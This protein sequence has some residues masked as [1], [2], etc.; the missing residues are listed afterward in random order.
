MNTKLIPVLTKMLKTSSCLTEKELNST[1]SSILNAFNN[2]QYLVHPLDNTTYLVLSHDARN[3]SNSKRFKDSPFPYLSSLE[4]F[5]NTIGDWNE[6]LEYFG[7][8]A[9]KKYGDTDQPHSILGC[10][11]H[12]SRTTSITYQ[13][14]QYLK[15]QYERLLT[16][17][18]SNRIDQY[19]K[20]SWDLMSRSWSFRLACLNSWNATWYKTLK[21]HEVKSLFSTLSKI[22]SLTEKQSPL[23]NLWIE[24][25][26]GK[27]RQLNIP[28]PGW[29]Y[30]YHML[31][32]FLSYIY[33]PRLPSKVYDGFIYNR[34]CKSWWEDLIWGT[35]LDRY[36]NIVEADLSSGFPNMNLEVVKEALLSDRLLPVPYINLILTHL[37]SPLTASKT[38]PTLQ[39]YIEHHYNLDWR[40]SNRSVPM[41]IGISP[42]LFVITL[43]WCLRETRISNA[44]FEYKFY[45]DDA[46][47]YFSWRGLI[48][49]LHKGN[50]DKVWL[51]KEFLHGR[52][53]L[54]SYLNTP[55]LFKKAGIKFCPQKSGWVRLFGLWLKP[56][57]SLGLQL[58]TTLPFLH[59]LKYLLNP[60]RISLD[61]MGYTRGRAA[62]PLFG[63][64]STPPSRNPLHFQKSLDSLPLTYSLMKSHY[65]KYFGLLMSK[66]Y[67][68]KSVEPNFN[69]TSE[70]HSYLWLITKNHPSNKKLKRHSVH[71]DLFNSG[72]EINRL[73]LTRN[74]GLSLD[75]K[76][77]F[78]NPNLERSLNQKWKLS[79][80]QYPNLDT[81]G[82]IPNL[83]PDFG[84]FR[85]YS[86]LTLS[87]TELESLER[88]YASHLTSSKSDPLTS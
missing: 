49:L 57:R 7:I 85:K 15:R 68:S 44:N 45:A 9:R 13:S 33:E 60:N 48:S 87:P 41:G 79:S 46:S 24:S 1:L 19:W 42:I 35:W 50:V 12:L 39:S 17:R 71:L 83:S 86:E 31:N 22:L 47:F 36:N 18:M 72:C 37:K 16:Y 69:L 29:R 59:Q 5:S 77:Y 23:L 26:K 65:R 3:A 11:I 20:L 40:K 84:Y 63:T 78:V 53:V 8:K 27:F 10:R 88:S 81:D 21:V 75:L 55:S 51:L 14:N 28:K 74:R 52:N 54:I 73:F 34:G 6:E 82:L 30:Y 76:W 38:F 64:S 70:P 80:V 67:S 58:Y 25:P 32:M 61:L 56:F 2:T 62:N 4:E 66:L 43:D